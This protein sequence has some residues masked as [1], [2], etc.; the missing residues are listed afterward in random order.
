MVLV[1]APLGGA[2]QLAGRPKKSADPTEATRREEMLGLR[3][4]DVDL[5]RGSLKVVQACTYLS[6]R[7]RFDRPKSR[8][9]RRTISLDE[10][11]A[12]VMRSWRS[13]LAL[14]RAG[15]ERRGRWT[16][17]DLVFPSTVGTPFSEPAL[18]PALRGIM[19]RAGVPRIRA[20]DLRHSYASLAY[21]AGVPIKLIGERMGHANVAFTLQTYVHSN[22]QQRRAAALGTVELFGSRVRAER[23]SAVILPSTPVEPN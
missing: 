7:P 9:G 18:G 19:A 20:Y 11:T 21:E 5:E 8:A 16:D 14:E 13:R 4:Q 1:T 10:G 23:A 3:W 15:Q 6:G 22:E 2:Q 12:A 17:L